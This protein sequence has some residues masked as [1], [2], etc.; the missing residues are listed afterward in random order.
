MLLALKKKKGDRSRSR[1][2]KAN[3][4]PLAFPKQSQ[5]WQWK[6][7]VNEKGVP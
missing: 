3:S 7:L 4:K 1:K 6:E 5:L 2:E